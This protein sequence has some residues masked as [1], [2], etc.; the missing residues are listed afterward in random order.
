M[1]KI[2][3][4]PDHIVLNIGELVFGR[5]AKPLHTLLGSCVAITL[6]HPQQKLS[7]ICHFALP[8]NPNTNED[9]QLDARY[10][11]D[12]IKL[13]KRLA[14]K[15]N[16]RLNDFQARIFGGGNMLDTQRLK[17]T[18]AQQISASNIGEVNAA[19][20]FALLMSENI[21]IL[22]A[23]VGEQGYRKIQFN[24]VN[25]TAQSVFVSIDKPEN[26]SDFRKQRILIVDDS[27]DTRTVLTRSLRKSGFDTAEARNG[28]EAVA[29]FEKF[30]P[31][32]IIMDMKMPIMDG[33]SATK[34][35]REA[36]ADQPIL[37]LTGSEELESMARAFDAGAT[38][39][40]SKP[41]RVPVLKQHIYSALNSLKKR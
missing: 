20:A 32:I 29:M 40:I 28:L 34:Q 10:G 18:L 9:R 16:V 15:K 3:C 36:H 33:V 23:D 2:S 13:F 8:S 31:D 4:T 25:G 27:I 17:T 6:W 30:N 24:P 11:D 35:L 14:R 38:D 5:G 26:L 37:M 1:K 7:G 19:Q 21:E 12:C 41:I 39:F 22:E